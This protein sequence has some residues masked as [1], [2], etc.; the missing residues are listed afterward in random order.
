MTP[1]RA[2]F[3]VVFLALAA[4]AN[5]LPNGFAYD[6]EGIIINNPVVT[7]G[8]YRGAVTGSWWRT[9]RAGSGLYRP[10]TALSFTAEWEVFRG[11]PLGFHALNLI[12]HA[13]VSLLVFFLVMEFV[14]PAAALVGGGLF[15]IHPLH[16]EVVANV[17][18]RAELYSALFYLAACLLYWRGRAW[19]GAAR[20]GRLLGLGL[21]YLLSLSGKEI[22]VTLPGMLLLMELLGPGLRR[23]GREAGAPLRQE[24][25]RDPHP[26]EGPESPCQPGEGLPLGDRLW[27][28]MPVFLVL[29]LVLL[30]YLGLRFLALGSVPGEMPAPIFDAVGG[31]ARFLTA[32]ALWPHFLR[33]LLFPMDLAADYDPGVLFPSETLDIPVVLGVVLLLL[34]AWATGK[35]LRRAPLPA[36]GILWFCMAVL[37]VANLLFPTGVLLAERTLY[38]PSVGLS[39][40]VAGLVPLLSRRLSRSGMRLLA[41]LGVAAGLALFLKTV[42]RNPSWMS[43]FV[44][45]QT[46]NE[47]H[48]E[49][50]R[51]FRQRA[52]GL[53]RVGE[54]LQ[55]REAWDVAVRL[56]PRNYTLLAQAGD[57]H[58]RLGSWEQGRA[59]LA[60]AT[61]VGPELANAYQLLSI[62]HLRR[63]EGR[64]GHR[65]ALEGLARS[66]PDARLWG[67]VSESYILK[68]DLQAALRA[69]EAA[70][71]QDP[72][73][74]KDW[75]RLGDILQGMGEEARA[76]DAW[77]RAGTLGYEGPPPEPG[78]RD[79]GGDPTGMDP[80]GSPRGQTP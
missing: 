45:M 74:G 67:L 32:L 29:G 37:P 5:A 6:D 65:V 38:L 66:G 59:Y 18:G 9:T 14:S 51:A 54:I 11:D 8:D 49:S 24:G 62:H 15:A 34:L 7:S 25:G 68:G 72:A 22:G 27:R 46:L 17:V 75:H 30:A 79:Q 2:A 13:L 52:L 4:Y 10:L 55:A 40:A 21:L 53:E 58:G 31:G 1:S 35:S 42:S 61:R 26:P 71:G 57:F 43:T 19:V 28:E 73:S 50:W 23:K 64:V 47:E 44:V 12:F 70:L 41:T 76:R 33:L 16:T 3:F 60:R 69:R 77:F 56:T 63:G 48:P 39:L 36:L 78:E 80:S 20:G